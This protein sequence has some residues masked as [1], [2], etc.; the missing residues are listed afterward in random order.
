MPAV[1]GQ[2]EEP[3][4][5]EPLPTGSL[6]TELTRL[7]SAYPENIGSQGYSSMEIGALFTRCG[8]MEPHE[9]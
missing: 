9:S 7:C 8:S 1:D 6:S 5:R 2:R 3:S 4:N